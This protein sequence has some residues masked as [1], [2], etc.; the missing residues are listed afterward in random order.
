MLI[1]VDSSEDEHQEIPYAELSDGDYVEINEKG[2]A[3]ATKETWQLVM[4][5]K[6]ILL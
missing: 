1:T 5:Q 3:N 4:V 2:T 6:V